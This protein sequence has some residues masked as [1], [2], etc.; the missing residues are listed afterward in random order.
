MSFRRPSLFI[1]L[2]TVCFIAATVRLG[3]WQLGRAHQKVESAA[4][5]HLLDMGAPGNWQGQSGAGVWQRQFRFEGQWYP[6]GEI[7]IDN[8]VYGGV[9]G[10]HVLTPLKLAD[11]RLLP[12]IR[13]WLP[14]QAGG[15][16]QIPALPD[17]QVSVVG[18][19]AD[20]HQH[21]IELAATPPKG[22]VWQNFDPQRF[23]AWL[24]LPLANGLVYQTVGTDRLVRDWPAPD[25]GADRNFAY[26]GQWFL[27]GG[28][29]A[30]FFIYFHWRPRRP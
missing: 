17:G 13:G 18:R 7:L 4:R 1:A 25:Q 28:L 12:V 14:R 19:L 2:L 9:A 30:V 22:Q 16:P 24:G 26:A 27:F 5:Q 11:G 6:H 10:Y 29:A 3:I 23:G 21:F 20:P 15:L 8:R